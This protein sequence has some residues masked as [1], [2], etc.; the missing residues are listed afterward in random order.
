MK[1]RL[2]LLI[3]LL[4]S[5][6]AQETVP[7]GGIKDEIPPEPISILPPP[8]STAFKSSEF[9]YIFD[10]YIQIDDFKGQLLVSPPLKKTPEYLHRGK[11]L[12]VS[13]KDTLLPNTTYQF[14][15]GEAVKD[16][17]EGNVADGLTYVFSTGH[18]ID[19]LSVTGRVH[20]AETNE[21]V[22]KAK[23]M[24]YRNWS[25]TLPYTTPPDY[26]ALT[27]KAGNFKAQYLPSDTFMLFVL[28]EESSNYK[29][30]GP[31]EKIG[32]LPD[33]VISSY[34]DSLTAHRIPL[35]LERD[36]A[37]YIK[38][39]A[40]K[41]YGYFEI[42]FNLPA[43][44]PSIRF[45]DAES[46][47]VFEALNLLSTG[48]DTLRSWVK[49]LESPETEEIN[50]FLADT[51][52]FSDTLTW[53]VET[54]PKYREEAKLKPTVSVSGGKIDREKPVSFL[55]NHPLEE[56]DTTLIHLIEDS[57]EVAY[58]SASLKN[59]NRRIEIVYP[60]K[61]E[62][63]YFLWAEPGA[64]KDIYG[65]FSDSLGVAFSAHPDDF[66]GSLTVNVVLEDTLR[67]KTFVVT[68]YDPKDNPVKTFTI[69][70]ETELD[71]G[72]LPPAKYTLKGFYDEND[73]GEWDTGNYKEGLQPE[74]KSFFEGEL[75]VRSNWDLD[76]DWIPQTPFD[77]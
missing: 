10:E 35:F 70:E 64:F 16:F 4:V 61:R 7:T 69:T 76:A 20:D 43:G 22:E 26:L 27:D 40:G 47:T 6:C 32:F 33:P 57:T 37:Q 54:D 58:R 18:Y 68:L 31:P 11:S 56:A 36:T 12:K 53:Y 77:N 39:S 8:L 19:S 5:G 13:W 15:F 46:E 52:G 73:N 51:T 48:G 17:N 55:F 3:L 14:N 75:N 67:D 21:P 34:R 59:V 38:E 44:K 23:V 29:Y 45:E 28:L 30:N 1:I 50:V 42:A 24:L 49:I 63:K 71:F 66:F 9:T 65:N 25:D 41:D 62:P 60:F 74:V 2:L 72:K